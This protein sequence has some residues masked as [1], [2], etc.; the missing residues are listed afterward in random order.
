MTYNTDGTLAAR[1]DARSLETQ[2]FY[3]DSAKNLTHIIDANSNNIYLTY[4]DN[5]N[6][7]T[8]EDQEQPHL[9]VH[10]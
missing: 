10:L 6:T 8:R 7:L 9:D 2:F 3:T 4:D 1:T 5:G